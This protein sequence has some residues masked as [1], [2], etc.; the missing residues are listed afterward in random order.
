MLTVER[1][2]DIVYKFVICI[3]NLRVSE[4]FRV[5]NSVCRIF[6]VVIFECCENEETV[7][8]LRMFLL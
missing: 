7:F 8:K 2:C 4:I 5:K 1:L 6:L 3:L